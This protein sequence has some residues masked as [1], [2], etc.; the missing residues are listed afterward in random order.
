MRNLYRSL[1]II[2]FLSIGVFAQSLGTAGSIS[3]VVTDPNGAIVSGASVTLSNALT[4]YTRTVTTAV[5]GSYRFNDIPP[6]NYTLRIS[7]TSFGIATQAV[8]VRSTVPMNMPVALTLANATATVDIQ[9]NETIV[10]NVPTTH[11]DV[12]ASELRRLP[13]S[14][15]GNGLSDAVTMKSPGVVADSNGFFHPLGDH[16]QTQFTIDNQPITD[17]Q[18]K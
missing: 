1:T 13:L 15:P 16:A 9:E 12:D 4:G 2:I 11:V 7:A 8:N 5:D 10:E 18:S 14:S 3:G 6:N 17:Q